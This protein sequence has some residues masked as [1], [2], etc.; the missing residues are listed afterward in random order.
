LEGPR[1][2]GGIGIEWIGHLLAYAVNV[3]LLGE[4]INII[5]KNTVPC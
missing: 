1:K 5:K 2:L 4:N 3:N